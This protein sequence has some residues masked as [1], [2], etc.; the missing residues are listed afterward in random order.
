MCR[1][2]ITDSIGSHVRCFIW[3]H[4]VDRT[5]KSSCL[6]SVRYQHYGKPPGFLSTYISFNHQYNFAVLDC[7]IVSSFFALRLPPLN[8]EKAKWQRKKDL[9][10]RISIQPLC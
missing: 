8:K 4:N 1:K 7:Y 2:I 10:D 5:L 3:K 6:L 9:R